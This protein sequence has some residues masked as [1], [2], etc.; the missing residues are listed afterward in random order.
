MQGV[1]GKELTWSFGQPL[2]QHTA[3][4]LNLPLL[5]IHLS[6]LPL[7]P[8]SSDPLTGESPLHVAVT[9]NNETVISQLLELGASLAVQDLKGKTPVMTACEYG[10]LQALEYLAERGINATGK[11]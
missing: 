1:Q 8:P 9:L 10:H 11:D 7:F 6:L 2:P 3:V 5:F 4:A